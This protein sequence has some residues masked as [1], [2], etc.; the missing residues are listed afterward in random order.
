MYQCF[1][2]YPLYLLDF[3]NKYRI[4]DFH[5]TLINN[6]YCDNCHIVRSIYIGIDIR[7]IFNL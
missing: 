6:S 2:T 1:N 4:I 7:F 3:I 5:N